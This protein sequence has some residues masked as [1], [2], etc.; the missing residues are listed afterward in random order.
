MSYAGAVDFQKNQH[1]HL[2]DH[3]GHGIPE[4]GIAVAPEAGLFT[5]GNNSQRPI[6]LKCTSA[7]PDFP[8][9]FPADV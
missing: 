1:D 8:P 7:L 2:C 3:I 4:L 6:S 9:A 5:C